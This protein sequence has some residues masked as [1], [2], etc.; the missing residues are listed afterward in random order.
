MCELLAA[1][2]AD[3]FAIGDL[4]EVTAG[5]ERYGMAAFGWGAAWVTPERALAHHVSTAAFRD[6]PAQFALAKVRT[7][8]LMV[9]LRRPVQAVHDRPAGCPAV[10][11]PRRS[12]RL[13]PQR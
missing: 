4:W 2:A 9:H 1:A 10:H 12:V 7:T 6:D 5:L 3:P 11:R 8:A 13:L